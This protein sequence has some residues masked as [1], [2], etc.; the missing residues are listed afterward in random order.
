MNRTT[1]MLRYAV[2]GGAIA[3]VAALPAATVV[4][5]RDATTLGSLLA[6]VVY[7]VGSAVCHQLPE[8]S[9]FLWGRQMPVCARCTGI[10]VG[11]ALAVVVH[12]F[13]SAKA[14]ALQ[15][16]GSRSAKTFAVALHR[17]GG[18]RRLQPSEGARGLQPSVVLAL[19]GLPTAATLIFEWTTGVMP[20]NWIR[21]LTGVV[22]GAT[23]A[24]LVADGLATG[25]EVN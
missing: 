9:F 22:L 3:W 4:G 14:F 23:A 5:A 13:R 19:A 16:S 6:V 10:Y 8:R 18:A 7:V 24:W 12:A 2:T 15:R 25:P 20:A 21:A 11:A 17:H 1:R